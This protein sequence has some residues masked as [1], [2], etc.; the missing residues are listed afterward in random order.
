MT[1]ADRPAGPTGRTVDIGLGL[2]LVAGIAFT[3]YMFTTSWGG[4]SWVLG[5]VVSVAVGGLALVRERWRPRAVV[6]GLVV[7]A[8]A[9]TVSLIAGD[10][11]PRE[12]APVTALALAV[13]VGSAVRT[14]PGGAAC[15]IAVGG[16]V[17][18]GLGWIEGPGP[19][20]ALAT[21]AMGAALL[22]GPVLRRIDRTRGRYARPPRDAARS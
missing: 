18:T 8:G 16:A 1:T 4:V 2:V 9:V 22:V 15:G 11:L 3:A 21:T 19:V 12:P 6:A 5:T 10:R 20:P 17:V 13:L 14:L 7:T